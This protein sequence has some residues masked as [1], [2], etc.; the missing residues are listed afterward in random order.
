MNNLVF[1]KYSASGNTFL[2][3]LISD[4]KCI[5]AEEIMNLCVEN[6]TDGL[7][8]IKKQSF[9]IYPW[10]FFNNDGYEA[11]FC[12][13]ATRATGLFIFDIENCN[14]TKLLTNIG[15]IEVN[16]LDNGFIRSNLPLPN[17][18]KPINFKQY[19]GFYFELGVKH[20]FFKVDNLNSIPKE[21]YIELRNH[22]D[23]NINFI[24]VLNNKDCLIKTFEKGIEDFTLSCGSGTSGA[25]FILFNH[26]HL[27]NNIC[28][29]PNQN[30][31]IYSE[32]NNNK[33]Y[34]YGSVL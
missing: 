20:C 1:K 21:D 24:E 8:L 5:S 16:R 17:N 12:G 28:F 29:N 25:F 33:L 27:N 15:I 4:F 14:K 23:S 30:N 22:F 9:G 19:K 2:I 34:L 3:S 6:R 18:I 32:F 11:N 10:K 7:V 13:N 31:C 26:F